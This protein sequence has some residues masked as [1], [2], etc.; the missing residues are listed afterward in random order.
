M[1]IKCMSIPIMHMNLKQKEKIQNKSSQTKT[2]Q[3]KNTGA[4]H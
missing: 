4:Y 3:P 2:K 1:T